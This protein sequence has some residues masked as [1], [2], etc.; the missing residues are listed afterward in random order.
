VSFVARLR[1]EV[2]FASAAE[3]ARQ[4][5]ADVEATRRLLNG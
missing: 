5:A 1:D 3:L 2:K 4:M